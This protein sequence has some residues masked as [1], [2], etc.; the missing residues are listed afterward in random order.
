MR[1][2][3]ATPRIEWRRAGPIGAGAAEMELMEMSCRRPGEAWSMPAFSGARSGRR[4]VV[5]A[6]SVHKKQDEVPGIFLRQGLQKNLKA[7]RIGRR[8]D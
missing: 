7:F 1:R 6:G 4:A 2:I 8:H 3:I 5:I